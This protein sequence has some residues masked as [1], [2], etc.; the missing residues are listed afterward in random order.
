MLKWFISHILFKCLYFVQVICFQCYAQVVC[1]HCYVQVALF[2]LFMFQ[3]FCLP[4]CVQ[5]NC[6]TTFCSSCSVSHLTFPV[7][8]NTAH[9]HQPK[10]Q[11][12]I[13][14]NK[15]TDGKCS[16][17][18]AYNAC[19]PRKRK[20]MFIS[21]QVLLCSSGFISCIIFKWFISHTR[22]PL[23]CKGWKRATSGQRHIQT[24]TTATPTTESDFLQHRIEYLK[25]D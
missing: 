9:S 13:T 8:K 19:T 14:T 24:S 23:A 6:F 7:P 22:V 10:H 3:V 11:P 12:K 25:E 15:A 16:W 4:S 5:V 2:P 17:L 21:Q 1:F 20:D 18:R